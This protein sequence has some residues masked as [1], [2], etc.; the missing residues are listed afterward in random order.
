MKMITSL[1]IDILL[2]AGCCLIGY[3]AFL[4]SQ[5]AGYLYSGSVCILL[6][7]MLARITT[8]EKKK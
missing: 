7:M 3:A 6:S 2:L 4:V 1:F 8:E 5:V